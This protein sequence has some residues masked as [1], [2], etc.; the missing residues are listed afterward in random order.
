MFTIS[1]EFNEPI[2]DWD[3]A[4]EALIREESRNL[5]RPLTLGDFQRLSRQHAIRFD[6]L[7]ATLF[8]LTIR[9]RWAYH[10]EQGATVDITRDLYESLRRNGRIE[11]ADVR[12]FT[13]DWRATA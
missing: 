4:L 11:V 5:D 8:E 2:P 12:D 13:G 9:G 7:M 10:D 1:S 6:D 3:V